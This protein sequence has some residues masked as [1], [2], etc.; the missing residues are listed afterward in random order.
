MGLVIMKIKVL[1]NNGYLTIKATQQNHF[2]RFVGADQK[3]VADLNQ[4]STDKPRLLS[5]HLDQAAVIHLF[6]VEPQLLEGRA[7]PGKI[8]RRRAIPY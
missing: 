5:H 6:F 1:N 2:G 3:V 7:F 4:R 8:V